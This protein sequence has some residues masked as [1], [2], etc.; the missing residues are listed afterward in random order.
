MDN[1]QDRRAAAI[2]AMLLDLAELTATIEATRRQLR[3]LHAELTCLQLDAAEA[4]IAR[5][6]GDGGLTPLIL[7]RGA[8]PLRN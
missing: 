8:N 5:S 3:T 1:E 4:A 7:E 6:E 2:Q